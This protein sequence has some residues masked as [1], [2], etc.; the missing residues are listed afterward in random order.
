VA[1]RQPESSTGNPPPGPLPPAVSPTTIAIHVTNNDGAVSVING[2]ANPVTA[3]IPVVIRP[4]ARR[5]EALLITGLRDSA[6]TWERA[7]RLQGRT[8]RD[9]RGAQAT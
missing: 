9:R 6:M 7:A 2:Q 8:A 1:R 5:R 3:I 4:L